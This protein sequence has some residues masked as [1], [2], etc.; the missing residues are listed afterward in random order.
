MRKVRLA[1][2][3][4]MLALACLVVALFYVR[5]HRARIALGPERGK[6]PP[7]QAFV[8]PLVVPT[9][10]PNDPSQLVLPG[11]LLAESHA[12]P[13][14]ITAEGKTTLVDYDTLATVLGA[15]KAVT[16][17]ELEARVDRRIVWE[18]FLEAQRRDQIRGRICQFRGALYRFAETDLGEVNFKDI[19]I[20]HLYEG[21]VQDV[22]GRWHSFYCFQ[23][24]VPEITRA[25]LAVLTGV[26]YKLIKYPTVRGE[27]LVTP[28]IVARTVTRGPRYEVP[29]TITAR[30]AQAAPP[31]A[32][33][34]MVAGVAAAVFGVMTL[35]F[36][37]KR[38]ALPRR[39]AG[40]AAP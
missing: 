36:R 37:K 1:T 29:Q 7:A 20:E 9:A 30:I 19:G 3:V 13:L 10:D 34:A 4:M 27:E 32:R 15:L 23:K 22:L 40:P 18:D 31:W 5:R 21:Q 11:L 26:F 35:L 39:P 17:D 8:E 33:Y 12:N 24:P 25:E 28:L 16:Q 6:I 14:R 38:P 2:F